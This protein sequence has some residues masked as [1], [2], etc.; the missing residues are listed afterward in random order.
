MRRSRALSVYLVSAALLLLASLSM[1]TLP[2][3]VAAS[4]HR[5]H[6][7]SPPAALEAARRGARTFLIVN[8]T[9]IRDV[10]FAHPFRILS[11]DIHYWRSLP[12]DWESRLQMSKL[13][14]LNTV[15]VYISWAIHEPQQGQFRFGS[16]F[17]RYDFES[18][19]RTAQKVG[20]LVIL[21]V[22][23]YITAEV[24]LGGLPYW[25]QN[26]P[27]LQIR[28][29]NAAWYSSISAYFDQLLLASSTCSM[30]EEDRSSA[31]K[32]KMIRMSRSFPWWTHM[33][34]MDS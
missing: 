9:F 22:G 16:D 19:I 34:I 1:A 14:G 21:R 18:F 29:P 30:T 28:R 20:L 23:P 13:A 5:H 31:S 2:T 8:S 7:E 3:P 17:P 27:G 26:V 4:S 10:D 11:G 6:I 33:H 24:D 32:L 25:L 15:T 12:A